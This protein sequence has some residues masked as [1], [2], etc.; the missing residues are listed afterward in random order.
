[1]ERLAAFSPADFAQAPLAGDEPL[2]P[3]ATFDLGL[4]HPALIRPAIPVPAP[5]PRRTTSPATQNTR[6]RLPRTNLALMRLKLGPERPFNCRVRGRGRALRRVGA[7]GRV[8]QEPG[9]HDEELSLF[10]PGLFPLI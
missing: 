10:L 5:L 8:R 2:G 7:A 6:P 3:P 9:L 4:P 1:M